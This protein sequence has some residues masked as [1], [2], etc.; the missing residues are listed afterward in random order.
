MG[1]WRNGAEG[2]KISKR[3]TADKAKV[4]CEF[5]ATRTVHLT[6]VFLFPG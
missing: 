3:K 1:K 6:L 2:K 4:N 5:L